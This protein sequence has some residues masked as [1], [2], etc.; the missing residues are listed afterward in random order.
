MQ[1]N[2][3]EIETY[4][5]LEPEAQRFCDWLIKPSSEKDI[6]TQSQLADELDVGQNTLSNWKKRKTFNEIREQRYRDIKAPEDLEDVVNA[7]R[8]RAVNGEGKEANEATETYLNWYY[9]Q[10]FTKGTN[11]N[12]VNSSADE[13]LREEIKQNLTSDQ[14]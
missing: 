13:E 3:E 12:N 8:D 4:D 9:N 11:I 2:W 7:T 14:G 5:D 1:N 10:D 6:D